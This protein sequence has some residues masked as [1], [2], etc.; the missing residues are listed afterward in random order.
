MVNEQHDSM[1]TSIDNSTDTA[2]ESSV[3]NETSFMTETVNVANE[4][5]DSIKTSIDNSMESP[6]A[7]ETS[8]MTEMEENGGQ[9]KSKPRSAKKLFAED[10]SEEKEL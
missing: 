2:M 7:S 1:E 10:N 8:F 4:Q 3:A 9:T 6:V 5:Q